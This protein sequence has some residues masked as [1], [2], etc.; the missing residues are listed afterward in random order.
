MA[1]SI[2][3]NYATAAVALFYKLV[4]QLS[5]VDAIPDTFFSNF[6]LTEF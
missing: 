1:R 4:M 6:S 2:K 3:I 5:L